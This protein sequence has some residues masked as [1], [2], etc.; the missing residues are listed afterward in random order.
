MLHCKWKE[1][2]IIKEK[3]IAVYKRE[4]EQKKILAHTKNAYMYTYIYVAAYAVCI[5]RYLPCIS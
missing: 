3:D 4:V 2:V 5:C 1:T